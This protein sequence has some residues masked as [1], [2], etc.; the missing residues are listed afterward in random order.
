MRERVR[1]APKRLTVAGPASCVGFLVDI[2]DDGPYQWSVL[3]GAMDASHDLGA[4]L[5]CFAGG[6]LGAPRG[7]SGERNGVFELARRSNVDGLTVLSGSVGKRVG[8]GGLRELCDRLRPLPISSIGIELDGHSSVRVDNETGMRSVLHHL[9][10]VHGIRRI[11][12]IRGPEANAEAEQRY[13]VYQETLQNNE[14]PFAPELVLPGDFERASGGEAVGTLLEVRAVALDRVGALV[15]ANDCM[16]LGALDELAKRGVRVPDQMAVVGFDDIE[17]ARFSIPPLTTVR[18][19][20][21]EL[22]HDAVRIVLSQVRSGTAPER[23]VR[24]AEAVIRRSCGCIGPTP[25]ASSAPSGPASTLG[26]DAALVRRREIVL[27][28]M[29]RAARG[30]LSGAGANWPERLLSA[31]AAEIRGETPNA[32][33]R[34]YEDLLRGLSAAGND[35]SI[36][37]EVVSAL[38][39]R[40]LRCLTKDPSQRAQAEELFHRARIMTFQVTDRVQARLRAQAWSGARSLGRA[41][42]AIASG[43]SVGDLGRALSECLPALRIDQCFV[44]EYELGPQGPAGA[45]RAEGASARPLPVQARGLVDERLG[46]RPDGSKA[47]SPRL[48]YPAAEILRRAVLPEEGGHAFVVLPITGDEADLG[49]VV[50]ELGAA[51]GYLYET[52]GEVISGAVTRLTKTDG[53]A[54]P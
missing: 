39:T 25:F 40:M 36:A 28:E 54:A 2:L 6:V 34:A 37:N 9:I 26:F 49:F 53:R 18:Q 41:V 22:G 15:A 3:R 20:S 43:R 5:L 21:Y 27:A 44:A 12:F 50:L 47:G 17:D 52:L 7:S 46:G 23:I 29:A 30:G 48:A 32:F 1:L 8:M 16:A 51:E 14:I 4:N 38:R 45:T 35:P 24:H 13:R 33:V 10:R 19:P 11:A 42:A 31:F